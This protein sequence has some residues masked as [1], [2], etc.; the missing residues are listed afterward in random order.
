MIRFLII[1]LIF[2]FSQITHSIAK[3]YS[4]VWGFDITVNNDFVYLGVGNIDN[5][6]DYMLKNNIGDKKQLKKFR[7][8][9][10]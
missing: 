2:L 5:G 4:T 1:I 10:K 7:N 9:L 6:I 3:T 8:T